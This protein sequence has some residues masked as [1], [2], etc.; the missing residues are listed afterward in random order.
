MLGKP[1]CGVH[2][3]VPE[4]FFSSSEGFSPGGVGYVATGEDG[5]KVLNGSTKDALGRG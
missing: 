3:S 2:M 1:F 5:Y 4:C